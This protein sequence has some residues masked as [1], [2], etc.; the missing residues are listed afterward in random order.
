MAA[1]ALNSVAGL[2]EAL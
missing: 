1:V 2:L